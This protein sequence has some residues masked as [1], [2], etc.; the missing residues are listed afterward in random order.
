MG[1]GFLGAIVLISLI[2]EFFGTAQ[3]SIFGNTILDL[4]G[5]ME[6]T[7]AFILAPGALLTMGHLVALFNWIGDINVKMQCANVEAHNP[8][9]IKKEKDNKDNKE[10]KETKE[11]KENKDNKE[12]KENKDNKDTNNNNAKNENRKEES[13][14]K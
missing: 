2:R 10:T 4:T 9:N 1:L 6:P 7:V 5:K 3:L 13:E 12:N 14:A 11:T 8:D